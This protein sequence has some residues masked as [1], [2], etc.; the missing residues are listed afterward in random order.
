MV[1]YRCVAVIYQATIDF[2]PC[3]RDTPV[4]SVV[5]K[6][7]LSP[8]GV[9]VCGWTKKQNVSF[10]CSLVYQVYIFLKQKE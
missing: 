9:Q 1:H 7:S 6:L 4:R 3:I 5:T 2:S 10:I 8:G